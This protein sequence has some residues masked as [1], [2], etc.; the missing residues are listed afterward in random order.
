MALALQIEHADQPVLQEQRNHQFGA[1]HLA[2]VARDIARVQANVIEPNRLTSR[3][4][5]AGNSAVQWNA[6]ARRDGIFVV[7]CE[8]AFEQLCFLV[9]QHYREHVIVD[10]LF[11]AFGDTPE[12]LFAIENGS[13]FAADVI[14]QAK[15]LRLI[16]E[17]SD[18]RLRNGIRLH[19]R[20]KRSELRELVHRSKSRTWYWQRWPRHRMP[21]SDLIRESRIG[22]MGWRARGAGVVYLICSGFLGLLVFSALFVFLVFF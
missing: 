15:R 19:L 16:R 17:S 5:V 13:E 4:G 22:H 21:D 8:N 20:R 10:D 2:G 18:Q 12:E 11:Y 1:H 7:H 9:P 6:E 3:G 14:E